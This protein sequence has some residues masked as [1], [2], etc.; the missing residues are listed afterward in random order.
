MWKVNEAFLFVFPLV[1]DEWDMEQANLH[2]IS[3]V[4]DQNE[5]AVGHPTA[6]S[7]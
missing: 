7:L 6:L 1:Q 4:L 5:V 2:W 3:E